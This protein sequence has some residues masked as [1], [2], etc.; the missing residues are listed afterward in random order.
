MQKM[1]VV[2][3]IV[4]QGELILA[5]LAGGIS[6]RGLYCLGGEK[7]GYMSNGNPACHNS[8]GI[9]NSPQ[10]GVRKFQIG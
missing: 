10:P 5:G 1:I 8:L 3:L 7:S 6:V 9:L 2:L 4:A